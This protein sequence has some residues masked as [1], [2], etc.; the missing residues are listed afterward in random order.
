[1]GTVPTFLPT[2]DFHGFFISTTRKGKLLA[3]AISMVTFSDD[4]QLSVADIQRDM[5]TKWADLPTSTDA[6][7][8]DNT[9]SFSVGSADVILGQ[10][11]APIPWSALE[12]PCATSI[13]WPDATNAL[14]EH[15]THAIVTVSGELDPIELSTVL[16]QATA[17]LMATSP[18]A[19]GVYWGNA[20]LVIPKDM[21]IDFAVEVLPHGPP[22]HVW[23]DFRVGADD[24]KSSSGFTTGMAALGHMEFEAQNAAE[25]PGELRERFLALASYVVENGPV[26]N[27]GN[28]VGEDANER[29]RVVFSDSAFGHEEKVMRLVYEQE[30]PKKPWWKLW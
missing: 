7:E 21:F 2:K 4:P 24:G 1:M 9:L 18:T 30:S 23:V 14:K 16:M 29:I 10:M 27:D 25:P 5:A 28:T 26:I 12:G 19:I 8:T 20:T 13:L 22:L 6:D 3:L 17:S 11:P 15:K